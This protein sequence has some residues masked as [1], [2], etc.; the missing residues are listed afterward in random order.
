[1]VD[2]RLGIN[3]CFFFHHD[4]PEESKCE[5]NPC[6]NGAVCFDQD[7]GGYRCQC[8]HGYKGMH[9]EGNSIK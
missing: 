5:P 1:M 2:S 6:M 8:S 3:I 9:C 4:H 7:D